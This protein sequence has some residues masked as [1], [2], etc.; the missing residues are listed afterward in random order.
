MHAAADRPLVV[1]TRPAGQAAG[2]NARLAAAGFAIHAMPLQQL[3]PLPAGL[4]QLAAAVRTADWLVCVSP[5]AADLAAPVLADLPPAVRLAAVGA[6]T[7]RR[8]G[9]L[10]GRAVLYPPAG[11]D[12]EALLACP[13]LAAPTGRTVLI[14][15]GEGGRPLLGDTLAARGARV[16]R[17]DGY[18]RI[19]A[20]ID[21]PAFDAALAAHPRRALLVTSSEAAGWLFELAGEGRRATLQSAV[22]LAPHPRIAAQLRQRGARDVLT[23]PPGDDATVA[24]LTEWFA[25]HDD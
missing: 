4:A 24:A 25:Q 5:S 15:K 17:I 19:P 21:W 20:A 9:A 23:T 10:A 6:P 8:M 2:L 18:R 11:S 7:A 3:Q 12:S 1:N 14:F 13:E 16:E 22:I